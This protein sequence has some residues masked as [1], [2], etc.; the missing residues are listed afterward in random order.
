MELR[1]GGQKLDSIGGGGGGG[2][3]THAI[4]LACKMLIVRLKFLV[5]VLMT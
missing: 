5:T 4:T 3:A 2:G 1:V